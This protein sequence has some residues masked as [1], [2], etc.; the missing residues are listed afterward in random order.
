[1]GWGKLEPPEPANEEI[2]ANPTLN[3][4]SSRL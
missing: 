2:G 4:G 1:M 3:A